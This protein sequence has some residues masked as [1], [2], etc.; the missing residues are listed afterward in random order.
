MLGEAKLAKIMANK[1]L[2]EEI[3]VVGFSYPVVPPLRA[4]ESE[5]KESSLR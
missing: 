2:S 4:R 3:Y 1:L 5:A